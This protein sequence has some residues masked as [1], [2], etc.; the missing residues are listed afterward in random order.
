MPLIRLTLGLAQSEFYH[1]MILIDEV[2][3]KTKMYEYYFITYF[4]YIYIN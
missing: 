4:A 3:R 1:Q 2:G